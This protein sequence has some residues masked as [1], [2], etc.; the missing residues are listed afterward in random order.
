MNKFFIALIT[1]IIYVAVITGLSTLLL[2]GNPVFKLIIL[3]ILIGVLY[4]FVK[5]CKELKKLKI[6][7][8]K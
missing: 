8:E 3:A 4:S 6:K 2:K 7:K 5:F 1:I